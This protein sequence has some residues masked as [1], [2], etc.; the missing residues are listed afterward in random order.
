MKPNLL[1][2]LQLEQ[3]F[4]THICE[5]METGFLVD[6]DRIER[7]IRV[8]T[9]I[10]DDT[11][12]E[13]TPKMPYLC[14]PTI[15]KK[16]GE[17]PYVQK[18]FTEAGKLHATLAKWIKSNG[19]S[20][21]CDSI[22]GPFTRVNFN[23]VDLN[24]RLQLIDYLLSV[25]WIPD[26]WNVNKE[27]GKRTSPKLSNEDPFIGIKGDVGQKVAHR[28]K[29]R[30]RKSQLEGW[31]KRIRPDGRLTAG[32][33][34]LAITGRLKHH[35]VVNIPGG[36]WGDAG[37]WEGAFFGHEMRSCF[38]AKKGY[39]I[40][41]CD[42]D[43]FQLRLLCHY[44]GDDGYT[45]TVVNGSKADGTDVHTVNAHKAGLPTRAAGK[46][47]IYAFLFGAGDKHLAVQL[48]IPVREIRKVRARFLS[49]LPK[50]QALINGLKNAWNRNG[51]LV[52]LDGRKIWVEYEHTLLVFLLQSAEAILM[53]YATCVAHKWIKEAGYDARMVAH[54]HDEYQWEVREDQTKEVGEL[55]VKAIVKAYE[56]YEIKVE[57]AASYDVGDSWAETH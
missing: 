34:G 43:Q 56:F 54:V 17:Y 24:S 4:W 49:Q 30:H 27:T 32:A 50:L 5:Q 13:I 37:E 23:R 26:K 40:L 28:L 41:G 52:G 25:G 10:M 18:P 38:I 20:A 44:M 46:K 35:T 16:D 11:Y 6:K 12:D 1:N 2:A 19:T 33:S 36:E 55:L 45:Q 8:L 9:R 14:I 39:K 57:G 22:S 15:K 21:M 51:Y 47:F 3:Q 31:H 7:N 42:A 48:G 53:K 29:C